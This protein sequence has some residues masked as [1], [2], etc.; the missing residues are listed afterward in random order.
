MFTEPFVIVRRQPVVTAANVILDHIFLCEWIDIVSLNACLFG[1]PLI[2]YLLR[3][4]DGFERKLFDYPSEHSFHLGTKCHYQL[5]A[6][7]K[8]R[9]VSGQDYRY[10]IELTSATH[11]DYDSSSPNRCYVMIDCSLS[12]AHPLSLALFRDRLPRCRHPPNG[13][14]STWVQS[15]GDIYKQREQMCAWLLSSHLPIDL[16]PHT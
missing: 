16:K 10:L 4:N 7:Q 2:H 14:H 5:D 1:C 11:F 15:F 9:N 13:K 12:T 6:S 8:W 3:H